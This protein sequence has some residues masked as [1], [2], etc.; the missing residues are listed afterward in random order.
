MKAQKL[1][2][3]LNS[4][5]FFQYFL[6]NACMLETSEHSCPRLQVFL[7]LSNTNTVY[8]HLE[9]KTLFSK[10]KSNHPSCSRK[11]TLLKAR[12]KH[13]KNINIGR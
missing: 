7:K 12:A 9:T 10:P 13:I 8:T 6:I 1:I 4:M 3:F 11:N 2:F 5:K